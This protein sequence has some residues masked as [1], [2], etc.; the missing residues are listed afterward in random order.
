MITKKHMITWNEWYISWEHEHTNCFLIR[1]H[2]SKNL[3]KKSS[4]IGFK[5]IRGLEDCDDHDCDNDDHDNDVYGL[6]TADQRNL[7]KREYLVPL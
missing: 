6:I 3:E 5:D 4:W 1:S 2:E 7:G